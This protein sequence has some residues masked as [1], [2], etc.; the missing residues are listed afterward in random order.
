MIAKLN[1][2][3]P[4]Q[5]ETMTDQACDNDYGKK[6]KEERSERDT[7]TGVWEEEEE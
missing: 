4:Q 1:R 7:L 2:I 3:L 5:N 6:E